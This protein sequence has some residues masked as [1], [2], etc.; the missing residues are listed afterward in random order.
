MVEKDSDSTVEHWTIEACSGKSFAY[1]VVV[2]PEPDG[3]VTDMVGDIDDSPSGS[4]NAM[5]PPPDP[6]ECLEKQHKFDAL[7]TSNDPSTDYSQM[8]QLAAD[9]AVCNAERAAP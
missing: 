4:T 8:A 9:L 7:N 2:F 6:A 1:E 5:L 3:G